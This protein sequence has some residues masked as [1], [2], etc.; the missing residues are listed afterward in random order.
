MLQF[1]V[2]AALLTITPTNERPT[3]QPEPVTVA[4]V[5]DSILH[6]A[7]DAFPVGHVNAQVGRSSQLWD[8]ENG[9]YDPANGQP[10]NGYTAVADVI[11]LIEPGG[12]LVVELGTND[13]R[14]D[15]TNPWIPRIETDTFGQFVADTAAMLPDDRCLA[16]VIPWV[17]DQPDRSV[18]IA[19]EIRD[20][21]VDQPC[22][23]VIDWASTV[24]AR[25]GLVPDGV[26]PDPIGSVVLAGMIYV[27]I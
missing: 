11:P 1:V 14:S 15:G 8:P 22:H 13:A 3:P 10:G 16:W 18:Q 12:W 2:A 9:P 26:H 25:P 20:H 4:I 23:T 6:I 17:P 21:I 5:G 19:A 7:R 24:Q 27:A